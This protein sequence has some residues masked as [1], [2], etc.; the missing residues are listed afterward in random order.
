MRY[1]FSGIGGIGM[2]SLALYKYYV[3]GAENVL[4]SNNELNERVEYLLKKGIKVKLEQ[5]SFLPDVD[6]LVRSTAIKDD[7]PEILEARKRNIKVIYRM[8]L[9]NEILKNHLSIGVTGT[10]GKTTTTAM[11]SQIFKDAQKNPTVFLGGIHNSLEDGNFRFGSE[12]MIAEVDESDGFIKDTCTDYSIVNNLRSDHLEHYDN[13]FKN[14]ELSIFQFIKNTRKLVLL[15]KDDPVLSSWNLEGK[16]VLYFGLNKDSD[17]ILKNRVQNEKIQEFDVYKREKFCGKITLKL[18]GLHYAYD[19]LA[20]CALALEYGI[21]FQTIRDS[22]YNYV[23]VYRRFNIIFKNNDVCIIDDY[24][25]TPDEILATINAT[26][27]YFPGKKIVAIFQPHR[28]SRL[29]FHLND[30]VEVLKSSDKVYVYRL[31]SAFE[32]PLNGVDERTIVEILNSKN[33][34]AK[35]YNTENT[36]FSD[37]LKEQNS[38]LLFLGAGDITNVARKFAKIKDNS[39]T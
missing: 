30:F 16:N 36:I 5:N 24:A 38:I 15:C 9:L 29:Y 20:S 32:E 3:S 22:L 12:L 21:D 33:V 35:F 13:K 1:Y 25:H 2:S 8:Q 6:I 34:P 18:P 19:A 4:G 27:E 10:D 39:L 17:Y 7:N 28:F 31:Y 11:L 23:S 26:R 37:L 14:L